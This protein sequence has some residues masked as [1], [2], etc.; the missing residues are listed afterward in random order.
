MAAKGTAHEV[1]RWV[2]LACL[3]LI[4]LAPLVV[5]NGFYFPFIT[6]KA[7]YLRILIE[8]LVAAWV[9]LALLDSAYRPRF[10]WIGATVVLFVVWL[11]IADSFAPNALKAFWSNFERMEGWV[12]LIHL[13]GF[14]FAASAVLRVTKLWRQ[15]WYASLSVAALVTLYALLQLGGA[16]QI[17]QGD[18][19]LTA[20]F[21][22]SIYL[23][24]YLLFS[25]GV[26]A[27]L[28][29]TERMV[30]LRVL[31][32]GGALVFAGL[33]FF[34]GTR[35]TAVALFVTLLLGGLLT[36]CTGGKRARRYALAFL[37]LAIVGGGSLYLARHSP[38]V[39]SNDA[40]SRIANMSAHQLDVRFTIWGI[41]W[42]GALERPVFG[43][44]QEGFNYVFNKYYDPSLYRQEPWF[45]RAHNTFMDWLSAGGFPALL[46]YLGLFGTAL[47]LLWRPSLG[48]GSTEAS[49]PNVRRSEISRAERVVLTCVLVGYAVHNMTVFDNL[50]S[51]IYFFA[52]LAFIDSQVARPIPRL[53]SAP[54]IAPEAGTTYALPIAAVLA[55][56]AMWTVNVSGMRVAGQL[57]AAM[58]AHPQ[59]YAGNL[60][61]HKEL[62]ARPGF[63]LQEVREELVTF[64]TRLIPDPA[65]PQQVKE[66]AAVLAI[67]EM[68]K[69][70]ERYPHDARA[71]MQLSYAYRVAGVLEGAYREVEAALALSPR[72]PHFWI[73]AGL[74]LWDGGD[75]ARANDAFQKAY[76]LAPQFPELSLY[77]AMGKIAI[78]ELEEAERVVGEAYGTT[79]PV[80]HDLLALAYARAGAWKPLIALLARRAQKEGA[81]PEAWFA[82]AQ[83]YYESGDRAGA[84]RTLT[85]AAV[86]FPALAP[87]I[88]AAVEEVRAAK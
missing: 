75:A 43:W 26:A 56:S 33:I 73:E 13:L 71:R 55:L 86:R 45:D 78:G 44:G 27:W 46:L 35:G 67:Q 8:A 24:I 31:L 85:D 41:A 87:D 82:L 58:S 80:D 38:V 83:A 49:T 9:V 21:G 36:A 18:T 76:A 57:I 23:A 6:G 20:S 11:A 77:A 1:A 61:M 69:H 72:K 2:A 70:V 37:A 53:A 51:Y 32:G 47:T 16:L 14:F 3:F 64:A 12:F 52:I 74:L 39:A 50:Y 79:T 88:Q 10:S 40:L 68:Q 48:R 7:F 15:W 42:Q 66:Q 59:G 28:S 60:A 62:A 65:V 54:E 63:A 19:R 25:A 30:W 22:N 4:P 29:V 81:G 34:T 17:H 84:I 5:V